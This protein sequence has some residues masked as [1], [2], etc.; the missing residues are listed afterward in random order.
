MK[1]LEKHLLNEFVMKNW[2]WPFVIVFPLFLCVFCEREHE[3][4][5]GI[6]LKTGNGYTYQDSTVSKGSALLVGITA[7][8]A[9]NNLKTYNISV[10]YDG[11][12]TTTTLQNFSIDS[13]E[14]ASYNKDVSFKVRNQTGTEKYYFTIVDVDGNIIQKVLNFVVE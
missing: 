7:A 4:L 8:K 1:S 6:E 3:P 12:H 13:A 2:I 10:A 11:A 14:S 9:E 5:P